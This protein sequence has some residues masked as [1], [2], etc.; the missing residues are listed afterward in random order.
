MIEL[1]AQSGPTS[2]VERRFELEGLPQDWLAVITIAVVATLCAH[3]IRTYRREA[4]A[5]ASMVARMG[6]AVMR[7]I[8]I[9]GLVAIWLEPVIAPYTHQRIESTTLVLADHSA[10]MAVA[11]RYADLDE[12]GRVTRFLE[13]SN[14][15]LA[16]PMPRSE[17][18]DLI[19][20][21]DDSALMHLLAQRNRVQVLG[22]AE[23]SVE[24]M[25]IPP[26]R[27]A[28]PETPT[29]AI[30]LARPDDVGLTD[31]GQ[32]IRRALAHAAGPLAGIVVLSDGGFNHG[33]SLD[34]IAQLV[35]DSQIP[36]HAVGVGDPALPQ[37]VRVVSVAGPR[38][39]F[40]EDPFEITARLEASS[41]A[42]Q[43]I[44]VQLASRPT[45]APLDS[46]V[47]VE[48]KNVDVAPDGTM[49]DIAF[50]HDAKKIG[51]YIYSVTAEP[52]T[53]ETL[54]QDNTAQFAVQVLESRLRVL[55][56]A[57][58]A[59]WTY[60]LL[61]R[62]LQRDTTFEVSTWLQSADDNAVRDGD[63]IIDHLPATASELRAYDVIVLLD[64]DARLL[65][66]NWAHL[67]DT[68]ITRNGAGVVFNAARKHTPRF[69]RAPT[70]A[71]LVDLLPVVREPDADL[72]L[73]QVGYYQRE[74][75]AVEF[76]PAAWSNALF[77]AAHSADA[78]ANESWWQHIAR[79]YWH[80]PTRSEKPAASVLLR[81]AHPRMRNRAG[82][83]VVLAT[84]FVGS[85][86][87]AFL[88]SDLT[89]RWRTFGDAVFNH[90]WVQ[91]IR[92][93][94][95][96]R[97]SAGG[98]RGRLQTDRESYRPGDTVELQ[99]RVTNVDYSPETRPDLTVEIS[100]ERSQTRSVVLQRDDNRPGW[101][102]GQA[103]LETA[104]QWLATLTL[105]GAA[106][107]PDV[108]LSHA[109][110]VTESTTELADVR[111]QRTGLEALAA[112][113]EGR[114]YHIDE[115]DELATAIPDRHEIKIRRGTPE[116]LWDK[117]WVLAALIGILCLEW[118]LRKRWQLM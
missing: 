22:F 34:T 2:W 83:H 110:G 1:L 53:D 18:R 92:Q 38:D 66:A 24:L 71:S 87:S 12:L 13:N 10:S 73:N 21:D 65:P 44:T 40:V 62:A 96:G 118:G 49:P 114:Y 100:D 101:Y 104:G 64:P 105:S 75:A 57:G 42:G 86:R 94:A 43:R 68:H 115:V 11:D 31:I 5:G 67:V 23:S 50:K 107:E 45:G 6:L 25:H 8:V 19:L 84:Q 58:G 39:V 85:G 15:A 82:G 28:D 33:E 79:V 54:L 88:A 89:W 41:L 72:L 61:T 36:V 98:G 91:L 63:T 20:W 102:H 9:L 95:E 116:P 74:S 35:R 17:L 108:V 97:R 81:H 4:R 56:V 109:I 69:F 106:D 52:Q 47:V 93:V 55:I 111:M 7:C 70:M 27:D 90:F 117:G 99:A 76:T 3:V 16:D 60:R 77:S 14:A 26:S 48:S 113:S 103:L 37:N 59:N 32:A 112:A 78:A 80:Y 30:S 46:A 29:S 51:R